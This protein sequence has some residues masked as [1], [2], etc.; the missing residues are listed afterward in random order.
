MNVRHK[1]AESRQEPHIVDRLFVTQVVLPRGFEDLL[2]RSGDVSEDGIVEHVVRPL[3]NPEREHVSKESAVSPIPV[4]TLEEQV[5]DVAVVAS[6]NDFVLLPTLFAFHDNRH[7]P[8]R[9][10]GLVH[11][12]RLPS[13]GACRQSGRSHS[14]SGHMGQLR[15]RLAFGVSSRWA[16]P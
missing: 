8:K 14:S 12:R 4:S 13:R 7:L 1:P 10:C 5:M 2:R 6:G 9:C 11:S 16:F 15:Q 3:I